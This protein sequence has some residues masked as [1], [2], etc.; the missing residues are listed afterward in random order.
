[1]LDMTAGDACLNIVSEL[2][3]SNE[4]RKVNRWEGLDILHVGVELGLQ[5]V[6]EDLGSLH[7]LAQVGTIN[8]PSTPDDIIR[9]EKGEHVAHGSVD[10]VPLTIVSKFDCGC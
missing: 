1:M 8:V 4:I 3:C 6:V 7:G 2:I 10:R 9:V 5:I